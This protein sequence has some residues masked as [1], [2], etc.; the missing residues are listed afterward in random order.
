[1]IDVYRVKRTEHPSRCGAATVTGASGGFTGDV[2][3]EHLGRQLKEEYR[4]HIDTLFDE[5]TALADTILGRA[6]LSMF[7]RYRGRLRELL[8]E[9]LKNAYI[10]NS[11]YVTDLNGRQRVF[12]TISI[13]DSKLDDLAKDILQENSGKLDYLSR[14]DEIRGLILDMLS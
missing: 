4:R 11:E 1:M 14:V 12:A 7:E 9:A 8:T 13:I 3:R 6:D 5:L 10:L 2:F